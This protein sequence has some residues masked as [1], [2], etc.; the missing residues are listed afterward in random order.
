MTVAS[1]EAGLDA[2]V[3]RGLVDAETETG[4]LGSGVGEREEVCDGEL[5]GGHVGLRIGLIVCFSFCSAFVCRLELGG[6]RL[7]MRMDMSAVF[8]NG[9]LMDGET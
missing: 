4:N 9:A 3:G 5:G 8:F 1:C 7:V 2:D 6:Q